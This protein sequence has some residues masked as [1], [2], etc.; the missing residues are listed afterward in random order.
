[1]SKPYDYSLFYDFIESY[2]PLGFLNINP[3]DPIM[4]KLEELMEKNDQ[5]FSLAD[6][7]K[8]Q[9]VYNSKR[10][11]KM[12]GVKPEEFHP[13]YFQDAVHPDDFE[14]FGLA[15]SLVYRIEHDIFFAE[16]GSR[17]LSANFKMKNPAEGYTNLLFQ[18]YIFYSPIPYK[19]VFDLQLYT[20][21]DSFNLK[22]H[23]F[24]H[25][26]GD[27]LSLFRFPDE[28]L[29]KIGPDF[30]SREMEIIRLIGSGLSSKQIADK[31]FI[32][33]HTVNTHRRN[34]LDQCG[35]DNISNLIYELQEQGLL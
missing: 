3:E 9:F 20:N 19:A 27:D 29:L 17:V 6:L 34:I 30:S 7:G 25:Y 5:F 8:M 15:R 11:I 35:K 33:V 31:L 10:S 14:R 28:N 2:L 18:C 13:G 4:L 24:H 16:K 12:I 22:K 21:I 26:L 1:M 23:N 32:S